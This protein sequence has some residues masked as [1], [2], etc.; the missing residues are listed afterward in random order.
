MRRILDVSYLNLYLLAK[1]KDVVLPNDCSSPTGS[2]LIYWYHVNM[3]K[4][5]STKSVKPFSTFSGIHNR[6]YSQL[7][8][9]Y[10]IGSVLL[11]RLLLNIVQKR[12]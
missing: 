1:N 11:V 5:V 12:N 3:H 8:A 10:I 4:K 7:L 9:E 2:L 6:Y